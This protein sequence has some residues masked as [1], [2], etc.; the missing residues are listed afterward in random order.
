MWSPNHFVLCIPT[1]SNICQQSAN[2]SASLPL[3]PNINLQPNTLVSPTPN[4]QFPC[5]PS[6]TMSGSLHLKVP[7]PTKCSTNTRLYSHVA[8]S[9]KPSSYTPPVQV[10][11]P[12]VTP[13]I[14]TTTRKRTQTHHPPPPS[15]SSLLF[16]QRKT[17]A[18]LPSKKNAYGYI[19]K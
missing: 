15:V 9:S 3:S 5:S 17:C 2:M 10:K 16:C 14:T 6:S 4:F 7:D 18:T 19:P 13:T 12:A 1:Q 11:P 8:A